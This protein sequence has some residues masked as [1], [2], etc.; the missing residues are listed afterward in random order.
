MYVITSIFPGI[1]LSG[2]VRNIIVGGAFNKN[3]L[4]KYCLLFLVVN[5]TITLICFHFFQKN[6]LLDKWLFLIISFLSFSSICQ[7]LNSIWF[8]LYQ[9]KKK[10]VLIKIF[11]VSLRLLGGFLA[12]AYKELFLIIFTGS[13]LQVIETISGFNLS[14]NRRSQIDINKSRHDY[15]IFGLSIGSSR[16]VN[17]LIKIS[18]EKSIGSILPTLLVFEQISA[19]VSSIY[20]KYLV[21]QFKVLQPLKVILYAWTTISILLISD[22]FFVNS[23]NIPFKIILFLIALLH[24][25]PVPF[26]Y[27]I[28]KI[29]G[30]KLTAFAVFASSFIGLIIIGIN[31]LYFSIN[32]IYLLSYSCTPIA[33]M[34]IYSYLLGSKNEK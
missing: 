5:L 20:E 17:A 2:Y 22:Y 9:D 29:N 15:I 11:S 26:T 25:V 33:V 30:L 34:L 31:Y 13:V 27:Y 7:A 8:Y 24:I 1:A 4:I 14:K 12:V 10:F 16:A 19:G 28:I 21:N 32:L 18:I 6:D 23:L 3:K